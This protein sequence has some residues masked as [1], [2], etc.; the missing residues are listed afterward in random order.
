MFSRKQEKEKE[1][2]VLM[3][4]LDTKK[5]EYDDMI[6]SMNPEDMSRYLMLKEKNSQITRVSS[7]LHLTIFCE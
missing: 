3:R 2:E 1:L 7:V 5:K 6:H 4:G